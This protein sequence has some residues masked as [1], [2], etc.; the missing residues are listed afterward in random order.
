MFDAA[1]E[2]FSKATPNIVERV[3]FTVDIPHNCAL[4][5]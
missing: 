3:L 5:C 1:H 4:L 2:V